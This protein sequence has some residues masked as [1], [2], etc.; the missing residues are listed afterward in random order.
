MEEVVIG[1]I[2][3]ATSA[4]Q[5]KRTK[6]RLL[7]GIVGLSVT[8]I[9]AIFVGKDDLSDVLIIVIVHFLVLHLVILII[10]F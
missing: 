9:V 8:S 2:L 10:Q 5:G 6:R 1:M 7:W 3:V 4:L